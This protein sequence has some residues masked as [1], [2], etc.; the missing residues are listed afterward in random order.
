[1]LLLCACKAHVC[2]LPAGTMLVR[3][4]NP[5]FTENLDT[6][7]KEKVMITEKKTPQQI[8]RK[9]FLQKERLSKNWN[10][11]FI[12]IE[13][14]NLALMNY[15]HF[16]DNSYFLFSGAENGTEHSKNISKKMM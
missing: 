2:I 10:G 9:T 14:F 11:M 1:M 6:E 12:L 13:I 3:K 15:F 16:N 7:T 5:L 8:N 4:W